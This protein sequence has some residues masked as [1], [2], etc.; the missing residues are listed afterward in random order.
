MQS[1]HSLYIYRYDPLDRVVDCSLPNQAIIQRF[2]FKERLATEVEGA[3]TRSVFQQKDQLLAQ[4]QHRSGAVDTALL[5]TDGQRSVLQGVSS[6]VHLFTYTPYGHRSI[7]S[8]LPGFNG[9][10]LESLT[11]HYLL[12]IGYRAF[13]P[14]L[15]RFNSPDDLSPFGEGGMNP[16]AY[17]AGDPVNRVDPDGHVFLKALGRLWKSESDLFKRIPATTTAKANRSFGEVASHR[18]LSARESLSRSYSSEGSFSGGSNWGTP[19]RMSDSRRSA[20][21]F[22]SGS[23]GSFS[24]G[25]D[26]GLPAW[27]PDSRRSVARSHS[28][29][30]GSFSG[31]SGWGEYLASGSQNSRNDIASSYRRIRNTSGSTS[32]S[33]DADFI[34]A[35]KQSVLKARYLGEIPNRRQSI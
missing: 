17:C 18:S 11:G 20:L 4:Q 21:N 10:R 22:S 23:E 6:S 29:S 16:Y 27:M 33:S 34:R 3:L 26:W 13:N 35:E 31:G 19:V 2:Y 15:M 12:G 24:G 9:E 30:E 32:S 5:V 7:K 14:V 25:S 28:G 1:N 8:D